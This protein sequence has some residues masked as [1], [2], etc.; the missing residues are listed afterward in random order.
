MVCN[1]V[2]KRRVSHNPD[3]L[4]GSGYCRAAR[5]FCAETQAS[6]RMRTR[7][8]LKSRCCREL[9]KLAAARF[10]VPGLRSSARD[11][12]ETSAV[13]FRIEDRGLRMLRP[14]SLCSI[15]NPDNSILNPQFLCCPRNGNRAR[16]R[17][18]V[19]NLMKHAMRC[20]DFGSERE[21]RHD[22]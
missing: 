15:V 12:R 22:A 8:R 16:A 5:E 10:Q 17:Q 18:G 6:K 19:P 14:Q 20:H 9:E 13:G 21:A 7:G 1:H 2:H 3:L 11:N 4:G